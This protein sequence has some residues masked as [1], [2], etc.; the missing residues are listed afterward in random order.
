[1]LANK[2]GSL[3]GTVT[4][5]L[6]FTSL[7]SFVVF[8]PM[9]YVFAQKNVFDE[10]GDGSDS[11]VKVTKGGTELTTKLNE[12]KKSFSGIELNKKLSESEDFRIVVPQFNASQPVFSRL[13]GGMVGEN[14]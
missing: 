13:S 1:L 8:S 6:V 4:F 3:N 14:Y 12:L 2:E 11:K 7:I 10:T 9:S 5:I